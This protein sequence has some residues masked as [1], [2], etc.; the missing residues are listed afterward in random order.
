MNMILQ[1]L[2]VV[3][4]PSHVRGL[5]ASSSTTTQSS[6][7]SAEPP[8]FLPTSQKGL[9]RQAA[10]A[11]S[12]ALLEDDI[13][14]QSIRLPLSEAMYSDSEEGFVADRAIGWQG[15]PQETLRYLGPL[16][17]QVL[18]STDTLPDQSM[19]AAGLLPRIQEQVLLDFD[20]SALFTAECPAG[21]LGDAQALLQPN[22][23]AYYRKI[24]KTIERQLP[25]RATSDADRDDSDNNSIASTTTTTMKQRLFLLVNPAW[26][27]ASSFGMF[28]AKQAQTEI[29]D[30]YQTT[31][32]VDQ[33]VV[34][35]QKCS[36]LKVWPHDWCLFWSNLPYATKEEGEPPALPKFLGSF[37][38]RPSYQVMDDLLL[39]AMQKKKK[40]Q[41]Q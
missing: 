12:H 41:Q 7:A 2:L 26:R 16:V 28:A 17:R 23:D 37:P 14:L 13:H 15:G 22:T 4:L 31:Y 25:A 33:F 35:G 11:I 30:R 3:C 10:S 21:P 32:A 27:D 40:Q 6:P 8:V 1:L 5:T 36:L 39:A 19:S 20:G 18:Q 38:D 29:L 9:I 24:R 34:R